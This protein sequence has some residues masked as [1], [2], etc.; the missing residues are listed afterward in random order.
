MNF[1]TIPSFFGNWRRRR[2]AQTFAQ[3]LRALNGRIRKIEQVAARS[4][5]NKPGV[6]PLA[7]RQAALAEVQF[8]DHLAQAQTA[9][10]ALRPAIADDPELEALETL[11]ALDSLA[12]S[13]TAIEGHLALTVECNP[14]DVLQRLVGAVEAAEQDPAS[15]ADHHLAT[16]EMEALRCLNRSVAA[17]MAHAAQTWLA[18]GVYVRTVLASRLRKRLPEDQLPLGLSPEAM[19]EKLASEHLDVGASDHGTASERA[20][21]AARIRPTVTLAWA[22][23]QFHCL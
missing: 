9:I 6:A 12:S 3:R 21:T 16:A 11:E 1:P 14:E 17:A 7:L 2:P 4:G 10:E 15:L 22:V 20:M 18:L 5:S 8:A 13:W 23:R 19:A